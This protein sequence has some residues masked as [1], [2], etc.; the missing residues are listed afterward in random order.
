MGGEQPAPRLQDATQQH[1]GQVE[2]W[3]GHNVVR[4]PRQAKIGGIGAHDDDGGAE[5][6][7]QEPGSA[8]MPLDRHHPRASGDERR[9]HR[10]QARAD[11]DD[12]R[13]WGQARLSDES[14]CPSGVELMPR[15]APLCGAHGGGS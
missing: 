10:S 14:L 1:R 7:G 2:W 15:P 3:V 11:V 12:E 8:G 5:A 13:A 9:R 6:L 4:P